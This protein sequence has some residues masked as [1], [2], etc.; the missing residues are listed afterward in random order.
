MD[1]PCRGRA[2]KAKCCFTDTVCQPTKNRQTALRRILAECDTIVGGGRTYSTIRGSW[3]KPRARAGRAVFH[4][5]RAGELQ[6]EWFRNCHCA[7]LTAGT[8]TMKE[9]VAEVLARLEE[10]AASLT[11]WRTTR[12]VSDA[13]AA[14]TSFTL[15]GETSAEIASWL[16]ERGL[17]WPLTCAATI[18]CGCALA[19]ARLSDCGEPPLQAIYTGIKMPLPIFL[20][21]G[22]NAVLNGMLAQV[23][24]SGLGFRQTLLAIL[25]SFTI[26]SMILAALSP[27]VLFICLNAPPLSS[28]A[29]GSG[30]SVTLLCDVLFIAYAGIAANRRLLLLLERRCA[31]VA[32]ARRVFWSWL[33]GNLF[34]GAQLAWVL[35]PFIGSP[36]LAVQFLRDD[37]LRGNFYE[38]VFHAFLHLIS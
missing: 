21:C 36:N 31:G 18:V 14:P 29:Q 17:R 32:A 13:H 24:G 3:S 35:R 16:D 1:A 33:A 11:P 20:T 4:I 22:A 10:I 7:G 2:R 28:S 38:A 27:I 5:E 19:T 25:M 23:L 30:H 12:L 34:L 8:S 26:S 9:T 15:A 6:S 37:P